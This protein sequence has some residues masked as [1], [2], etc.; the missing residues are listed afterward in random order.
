MAKRTCQH[1]EQ[2]FVAHRGSNLYCEPCGPVASKARRA[3]YRAEHKEAIRCYGILYRAKRAR[4]RPAGRLLRCWCGALFVPRRS[5]RAYCTVSCGQR[6]R[7]ATLKASRG[8]VVA[9]APTLLP[10]DYN[11]ILT[12]II[13]TARRA[14]A[15][16][17]YENEL[18][19]Q[20]HNDKQERLA[21]ILAGIRNPFAVP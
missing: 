19:R 17:E 18:A 13:E 1:C 6:Y 5:D 21:G 20:A 16:I 7:R 4:P 10:V 9:P 12:Q 8:I 15:K 2:T 3:L 14:Q 11:L